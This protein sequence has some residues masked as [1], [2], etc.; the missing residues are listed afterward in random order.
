MEI[1]YPS[2]WVFG[3]LL[4][5][6][7]TTAK[8]TNVSKQALLEAENQQ[9]P[10]WFVRHPTGC[11]CGASMR[12]IVQC[13]EDRDQTLLQLGFS[14][15]YSSTQDRTLVG[16][17][18]FG[19]QLR[20]P[21]VIH[22]YQIELPQN[23]SQLNDFMCGGLKRTGQLCSQCMPGFGPVVLSYDF[24]CTKCMSSPRG[25]LLY[26]FLACVPTTVFFVVVVVLNVRAAS[27]QMNG[28]VFTCQYILFAF[29]LSPGAWPLSSRSANVF[30]GVFATLLGIWN[31]D[32]FRSFTPF[33]ISDKLEIFHVLAMEYLIALYPLFLI[34][35][36]YVCIELHA[37]GCK[38]IVKLWKPFHFCFTRLRR[39]WDS[40]SSI[41]QAFATF[42]LLSYSK[43]LSISF[44]ILGY[45]H[46]YNASGVQDGPNMVY[47]NPSIPFF[48]NHHI[49]YALL[50][51]VAL[52]TFILI[53]L[54][55][56]C[57]YPTRVFQRCLGHCRIRWHAI[58]AFAEAFNG[59][60][61]DGTKGTRDYRYFGGFY[62]TLRIL[63]TLAWATG[64]DYVWIL[65]IFLATVSSV[66]FL[67]LKPYKEQWFNVFDGLIFAVMSFALVCVVY[68]IFVARI[69][70]S[71][72]Y[73]T[74]ILPLVYFAV[75]IL[76]KVLLKTSLL[77]HH[78]RLR[79]L[80]EQFTAY[81]NTQHLHT[82]GHSDNGFPDR[83][84]N[85][86]CYNDQLES[87]K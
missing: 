48:S 8:C 81:R 69:P 52:S 47:F 32:Y 78:Q 11:K 13:E 33:C 42:L 83:L 44:G 29:T 9:C 37:R 35:L 6:I 85:P 23:I 26:V 46:L 51:I 16:R 41:I 62:L 82:R 65:F 60:Y 49:P 7:L 66:L 87:S 59:C 30:R 10:T 50:A 80:M 20:N 15:T 70:D 45:T 19:K 79:T 22:G 43:F 77:Q 25:E 75:Y 76:C 27:A 71:I 55:F 67:S 39:K 34:A 4:T 73:T 2:F 63:Y 5:V 3:I 86:E 64:G 57:L 17:S 14:M 36:T 54:L 58:H 31:L 24:A 38:F 1:R 68:K 56:L 53:P 28:I 18:P 21:K 61:K 84:L 72:L 74:T 12:G 40:K